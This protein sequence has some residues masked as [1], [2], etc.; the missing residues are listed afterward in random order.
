[1]APAPSRRRRLLWPAVSTVLALLVLLGLGAWQLR[2]LAWKQGLLAEIDRAEAAPPVPLPQAPAPFAKVEASGSL[3][4][5]HQAR[6]GAEVRDTPAGA[7][8]GAQSIAP[9]R[10]DD[11]RIVLVDRGFVP[12]GVPDPAPAG[13]VRIAAYVRPAD[14]PGWFSAPDDPAG[15]RFYTLDPAAIGAALG[16]AQV[17]PF[18]LVALG[19]PQAGTYPD[20]ARHL[21]RPPNDHLNYALTWFGLALALLVVFAA[22]SRKVLRS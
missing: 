20:P 6:Y 13:R 12:A 15:R 7:V 3:L 1:M 17:A 11:G 10:L 9:L 5:D 14:H 19:D 18:T 16:L 21:P 2:R 8:M 22:Y 4:A